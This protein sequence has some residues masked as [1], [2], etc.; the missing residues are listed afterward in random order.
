MVHFKIVTFLSLLVLVS[1]VNSTLG[2]G[3]KKKKKEKE[4]PE[5][6]V[7]LTEEPVLEQ[8]LIKQDVS[9]KEIIKNNQ[10]YCLPCATQ[11]KFEGKLLGY[12]TPWNS[13]GKLRISVYFQT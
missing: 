2:P 5:S 1:L 6:K 4:K 11:K 13:K 12:V 10:K 8:N 7:K 3:D 9:I